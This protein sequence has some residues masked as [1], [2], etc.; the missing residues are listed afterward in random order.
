MDRKVCDKFGIELKEGDYVCFTLS[1]RIDAKPIVKAKIAE[2]KYGK[3]ANCD[4]V[5]TDWVIPEYVEDHDVKWATL[6][7][8]LPKK[9]MPERVVKC[10]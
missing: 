3:K 9:V 6:E 7:G 2:I 5:F 10:Y 4:G 8:K 1:M